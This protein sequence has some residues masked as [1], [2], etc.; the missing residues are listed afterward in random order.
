MEK[1][2]QVSVAYALRKRPPLV[3][4]KQKAQIIGAER[5]P[6]PLGLVA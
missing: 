5:L 4:I 1:F 3:E 6:K 2:T